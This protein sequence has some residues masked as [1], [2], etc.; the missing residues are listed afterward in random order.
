MIKIEKMK[1]EA[2]GQ[3]L[4]A[5]DVLEWELNRAIKTYKKMKKWDNVDFD[6]NMKHWIQEKNLE[7]MLVDIDRV[8]CEIGIDK[9][10]EKMA[11]S[12]KLGNINSVIATKIS[13]G[14]KFSITEIIVPNCDMSSSEVLS[15]ITD[16]M[17]KNTS[18]HLSIN[19]GATPD[20]Y[21][22]QAVNSDVQEVLEIT[23]GS[24]LPTHFFANYGD[25]KG[26]QSV[27]TPEFDVQAPGT[28]KLADG[29]IIGGVRHQVKS[30]GNGF[31]FKALVEFPSI[32][33]NYMIRQHEIHLAC[34]FGHWIS[35]VID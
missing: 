19:L 18:E 33:P 21:A 31:R 13:R 32:L 34:E 12:A 16:I 23:G 15:R 25:E 8:K 11:A 20:H 29:T 27:F 30:E 14:R 7:L 5:N 22:L 10:R 3:E 28:A 6:P 24:P 35:A 1:F 9:L 2:N 17:M 26:L 4:N